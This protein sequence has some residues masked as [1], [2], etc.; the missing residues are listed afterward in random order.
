MADGLAEGDEAAHV[1]EG[2]DGAEEA[3]EGGEGG[4]GGGE[5]GGRG[6]GAWLL[7]MA[8]PRSSSSLR[9][10]MAWPGQVWRRPIGGEGPRRGKRPSLA[11]ISYDG[12]LRPRRRWM[13]MLTPS[14]RPR[15]KK[16]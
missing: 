2:K 12:N 5:E 4:G 15:S 10:M 11:K 1:E 8:P 14:G 7:I 9:E 16:G 3:D 6:E 13:L